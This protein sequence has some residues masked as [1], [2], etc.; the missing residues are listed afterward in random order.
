MPSR[1]ETTAAS[2]NHLPIKGTRSRNRWFAD[3]L[4]EGDG[5]ELPVPRAM[6]ARPEAK[7]AGFGCV[8]RRLS[9]AAVGGHQLRRKAKSRNRT[10]IARGTG[11]LDNRRRHA[12]EADDFRLKPGLHRTRNRKFESISLQR[13]VRCE[14]PR[15]SS[16]AS[17]AMSTRLTGTCGR[18]RRSSL[19]GSR[20][21]IERWISVAQRPASTTLANSASNP[22]PV[23]FT[24]RP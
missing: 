5:F 7:I 16:T 3:S 13:R 20:S 1:E 15:R 17:S 10:L 2:A 12:A 21:P 8:R 19:P 22:S 24:M 23:F 14:P 9:A 4:L 6:Q 18:S 11:S